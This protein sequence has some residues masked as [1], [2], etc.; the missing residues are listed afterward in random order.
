MSVSMGGMIVSMWLC[1]NFMLCS[2]LTLLV[3]GWY[4]QC[5]ALLRSKPTHH[6][7]LA[8]LSSLELAG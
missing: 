3:L 6:A 1:L 4:I 8:L 7:S 5:V 2:M